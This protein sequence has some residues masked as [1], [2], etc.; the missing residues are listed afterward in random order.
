MFGE[1]YSA[2]SHKY[3]VNYKIP[4]ISDRSLTI[5][6]IRRGN[7]LKIEIRTTE[8]NYESYF[9]FNEK[10]EEITHANVI[11]CMTFAWCHFQDY[12]QK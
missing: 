7:E 8:I 2:G 5:A 4:V 9:S 12:L 10:H 11:S 1:T 3:S 6:L